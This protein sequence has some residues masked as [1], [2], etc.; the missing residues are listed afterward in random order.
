M[1]KCRWLKP[2]L[3]T[4]IK[5]LEWTPENKLRHPRFVGL[6]EDKDPREIL[7]ERPEGQEE[8]QDRRRAERLAPPGS[9]GQP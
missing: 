8:G 1:N 2:N 5:F 9:I 3:V 7:Q 4:A 6:R